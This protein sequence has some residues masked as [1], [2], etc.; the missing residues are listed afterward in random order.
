MEQERSLEVYQS[1]SRLDELNEDERRYHFKKKKLSAGAAMS[2]PSNGLRMETVKEIG[3][4]QALSSPHVIRLQEVVYEN[5][6]DKDGKQ[7]LDKD[8]KQKFETF[9]CLVFPRMVSNLRDY[10][11]HVYSNNLRGVITPAV[12]RSYAAQLLLALEH[13]HQRGFMHRNVT[14]ENILLSSDGLIKLGGFGSARSFVGVNR[15]LTQEESRSSWPDVP[16]YLAPEA[17]LNY[18][19]CS[20]QV[21]IWSAGLVITEMYNKG[22]VLY[23]GTTEVEQL[24]IIFQKRGTPSDSSWPGVT[25]LTTFQ[26]VAI[27]WPGESLKKELSSPHI[28]YQVLEL[29]ENMLKVNPMTRCTA[30]AALGHS[31]F[32]HPE[33][34]EDAEEKQEEVIIK[35]GSHSSASK[36]RKRKVGAGLHAN[37]NVSLVAEPRRSARLTSVL[38]PAKKLLSTSTVDPLAGAEGDALNLDPS[39][40]NPALEPLMATTLRPGRVRRAAPNRY[41]GDEPS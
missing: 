6:K 38:L 5:G 13:C 31:Y 8:G 28:N 12:K 29:L 37:G 18:P 2:S 21:D 19:K 24:V 33:E 22:K 41:G 32:L 14:P 7:R 4:L 34:I 1:Q 40:P 26:S 39:P 11:D 10:I 15:P 16:W 3:I 9:V 23:P 20:T 30:T 25:G 36:K 17:L 27:K 35:K